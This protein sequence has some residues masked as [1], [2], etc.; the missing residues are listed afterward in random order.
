MSSK[1]DIIKQNI[2]FMY[3][4]DESHKKY[5]PDKRSFVKTKMHI[6]P[7]AISNFVDVFECLDPS[8]A[9]AVCIPGEEQSPYPSFEHA[10]QAIKF[11][12]DN[13]RSLIRNCETVKDAKKVVSKSN[14]YINTHWK[15]TIIA[16][17]EKLLRDKFIRNKSLRAALLSTKK[18][19]L[20]FAND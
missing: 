5:D 12:N 17:A 15:D 2:A 8:Y 3:G 1:Q 7:D 4:R 13:I 16:N 18:K 19:E 10:L 6:D 11:P 14:E 20:I 9:C